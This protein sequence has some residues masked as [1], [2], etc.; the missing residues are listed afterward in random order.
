VRVNFK[1]KP[2]LK[3]AVNFGT[4]RSQGKIS[5]ERRLAYSRKNF[6]INIF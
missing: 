6:G 3:P 4:R 5:V 1:P 2:E